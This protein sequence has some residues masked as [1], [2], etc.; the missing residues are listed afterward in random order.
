MLHGNLFYKV[1]NIVIYVIKDFFKKNYINGPRLLK[2]DNDKRYELQDV[3]TWTDHV[4]S[5]YCTCGPLVG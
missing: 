4:F 3:F 1:V 2:Y 5:F